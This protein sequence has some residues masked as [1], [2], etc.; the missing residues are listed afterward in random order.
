MWCCPCGI[1]STLDNFFSQSVTKKEK[2]S[3]ISPGKVRNENGN[4]IILALLISQEAILS[5]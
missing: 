4:P 5:L 2:K 1:D 3:L